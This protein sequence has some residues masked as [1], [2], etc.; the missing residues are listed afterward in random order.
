MADRAETETREKFVLWSKSDKH[1]REGTVLDIDTGLLRR[2]HVL[3]LRSPQ[4]EITLGLGATSAAL[5]EFAQKGDTHDSSLFEACDKADRA[6]ARGD[7]ET[8][9]NSGVPDVI[10]T[11]ENPALRRLALVECFLAK[12]SPDDPIRPGYPAGD[13]EGRGGQFMPKDK[14]AEALQ[15]LKRLKALREFRAAAQ[16]ALIV[17]AAA[18]L[19]VVPGVDVAV[20]VEAAL[21]LGRIAIELG[22]DEKEI[23]EAMDFVKNGPYSVDELRVNQNDVSFS[24][25]DAFKKIS[26]DNDDAIVRRYPITGSGN[27]YHHIVEQGG[28]NSNNF[29]PE[30]LQS[31]KNIIPL[32]GPIHDMVS[33]HYSSEYD[34]SGKTVRDWLSGQSFEQQYEYGLQT[35]RDLAIVK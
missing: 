23:S 30:Q 3:V 28:D 17:L 32:P 20:D 33:A 1:T 29:T 6:I 2:D 4:A 14:S 12:A 10:S 9:R 22:N 19:E 34:T 5:M 26:E 13:P 25:F 18:P 31:T 7:F 8:L 24:S 21:Q 35:L 16:A 27:E 11:I 15:R